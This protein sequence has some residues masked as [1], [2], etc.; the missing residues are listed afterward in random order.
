[1]SDNNVVTFPG[2]DYLSWLSW[3]ECELSILG[4]DFSPHHCDWK[5]LF[6]RGLR[7]ETAASQAARQFAGA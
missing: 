1:M 5:S 4:I 2:R 3:V 6:D 7:P